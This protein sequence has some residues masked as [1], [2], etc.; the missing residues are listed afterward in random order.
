[1][2]RPNH[3]V[4]IRPRQIP[5]PPVRRDL[6]QR[7]HGRTGGISGDRVRPPISVRRR[8]QAGLIKPGGTAATSAATAHLQDVSLW[9]GREGAFPRA[10]SSDRYQNSRDLL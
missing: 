3:A 7:R 2:E 6:P 9:E 5:L 4:K 10:H 1:M 8:L